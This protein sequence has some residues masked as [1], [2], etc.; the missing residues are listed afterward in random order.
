MELLKGW[1]C[2]TVEDYEKK[3][4][5]LQLLY[6][7]TQRYAGSIRNGVT[8]PDVVLINDKLFIPDRNGEDNI[9]KSHIKQI[10][11]TEL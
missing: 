10:D 1:V 3:Q 7:I 9:L 11:V 2:D 4:S 5:E 8:V 6:N